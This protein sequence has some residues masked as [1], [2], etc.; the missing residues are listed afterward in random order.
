MYFS[1][2]KIA[3]LWT[4]LCVCLPDDEEDDVILYGGPVG[5]LTFGKSQTIFMFIARLGLNFRG[6][7]YAAD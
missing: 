3:N 5:Q 1:Y 4:R 7:T 6:Q 2:L